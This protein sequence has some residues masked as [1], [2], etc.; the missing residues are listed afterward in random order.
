VK[1]YAPRQGK[2]RKPLALSEAG[3]LCLLAVQGSSVGSFTKDLNA[4][5]RLDGC[6]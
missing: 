2:G 6:F 1:P 5:V 4:A 3:K